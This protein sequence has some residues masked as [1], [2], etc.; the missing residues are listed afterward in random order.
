MERL[1][2][3]RTRSIASR[4][5]YVGVKGGIRQHI[6]GV[7][8]DRTLGVGLTVP[9]GMHRICTGICI[10]ILAWHTGL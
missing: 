5:S 9:A 4:T 1:S 2:D 3:R 8:D 10:C 7:G 6:A